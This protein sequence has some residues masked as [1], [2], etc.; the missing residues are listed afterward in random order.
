MRPHK[1]LSEHS[2]YYRRWFNFRFHKHVHIAI[3]TLATI[4]IILTIA[5]GLVHN[6]LALSTW[7]QSDWS[8]RSRLQ[9]FQP[10][11]LIH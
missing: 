5:G 10:I 8:R 4:A 3:G 2:A 11:L 9:Y 6:V 1:Y 7:V